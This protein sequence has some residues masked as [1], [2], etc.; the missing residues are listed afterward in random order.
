VWLALD[1]SCLTLSLALADSTKQLV[2]LE[3]IGPPVQ[4]SDALPERLFELLERH[5]VSLNQLTALVVGLG[6]GSFTG[7][8]V[9]LSTMK[10]LSYAHSIPLIGVSS[11]QAL[12]AEVYSCE[13]QAG[14][15]V[16]AIATV[17]RGE[18]Y[19]ARFDGAPKHAALKPE[20][21]SMRVD[22]F[23]KEVTRDVVVCG[24]A[25]NDCAS[26]LLELGIAKS[27]LLDAPR[28]ASAAQ[29]L[30]LVETIPAYDK[31]A[32]FSLE[33]TYIRGSGAEENKKFP[34]LQGVV[35]AARPKTEHDS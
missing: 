5:N 25:L 28:V 3:Y 35:A 23:A 20:V 18:V 12:A 30:S 8:R 7:L 21:R 10:A 15:S 33:P 2:E 11:L 29:L 27:Q 1:S 6:P 22:E 14:G 19:C 31:Q 16:L 32:I 4:Q 34:P 24:P 9:G 26:S 13:A 17:K